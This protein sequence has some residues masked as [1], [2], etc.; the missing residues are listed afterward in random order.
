[1]ENC[2][3]CVSKIERSE[4]WRF[5]LAR[6]LVVVSFVWPFVNFIYFF[7]DATVEINF[8]LVFVAIG[9]VPVLLLED[10]W[11]ALLAVTVFIVAAIWGPQGAVL[12]LL[13]GVVPCLFLVSLFRHFV[14]RG[15][16]LIP[17]GVAYNAL[18]LFVGFSVLQHINFSVFPVIP[19]WLTN[20]LTILVP[21]YMDMPYDEFGARG[22]QGWASEPSSAAMTC[23]SFCVVAVQQQP[24]KRWRILLLFTTLA[25]VNKSVYAMLFLIL[26]VLA[27]PWRVKN[28]L[29]AVSGVAAFAL[30][31]SYFAVRTNR[32]AD[33]REGVVIY[34]LDEESNHELMRFAQISYPLA[35]FPRL[36]SPVTFFEHE[37]QPLGLLPLLVGYGSVFGLLLYYCVMFRSFRLS[38][39]RAKPLGLAAIFILSFV[40]S[41]DFIP[42]IVAFAYAMRPVKTAVAASVDIPAKNWLGR[43]RAPLIDSTAVRKEIA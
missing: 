32:V 40:S 23:F 17:R 13:I 7:P 21:R 9:L 30:V 24:E 10:L 25:V 42:V 12:R 31:F 34:G 4:S 38:E 26:L 14:G 28:R 20:C 37:M 1:M 8:L 29:R 19:D 6:F 35:S 11:S 22:V 2:V 3:G 39:A 15:K 33:L 36:Y 18:L 41:P 43:L 5:G 27:C 16:E